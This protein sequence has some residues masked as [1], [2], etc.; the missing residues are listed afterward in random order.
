MMKL[1][2]EDV[3][4]EPALSG[5][6]RRAKVPGGWIYHCVDDV[7]MERPDSGLQYGLA[8]RTSMCFV[9]DDKEGMRLQI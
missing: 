8:W 1:E 7:P 2:W 3:E 5:F 4:Q 9:P 6:M